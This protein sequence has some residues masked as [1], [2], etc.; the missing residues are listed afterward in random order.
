METGLVRRH[1]VQIIALA[2]AVGVV[3]ALGVMALR[4]RSTSRRGDVPPITARTA[5]TPDP[6]VNEVKA[7]ARRFIEAFWASARTGD[8][9]LV[10]SLTELGTQA[11]GNALVN[12]TISRSSQAN[13][14]AERVDFDDTSWQVTTSAQR[15]TVGVFYRLFGHDGDWPSLRPQDSDHET[16][17]LH[18]D[19]QMEIVG[20]KWLITKY[21]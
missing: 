14:L 19:L 7:A 3:V 15:A 6:R 8:P 1:L 11:E 12:A 18:A 10:R 13:F 4:P 17:T 16:R 5:A 21:N 20:R 2:V 9:A